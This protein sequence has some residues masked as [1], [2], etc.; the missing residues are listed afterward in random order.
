MEGWSYRPADFL[1]FSERVYWRLFE[2]QDAA[3]WP[4]Q[5]VA[6]AAG[7]AVLLLALRQRRGAAPA[8]FLIL[9]AAWLLVAVSFLWQR[10]L[11][12]NWAIAY[13]IPFFLAEAGLLLGLLLG[14]GGALAA[15]WSPRLLAAAGLLAYALLAHPLLP[16]V[17]A[18]P[19]ASAELFALAPDPTAIVTLAVGAMLVEPRSAWLIMPVP[20]LWCLASFATLLTLGSWQGWIVLAAPVLALSV[21]L[22]PADGP[23]GRVQA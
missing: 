13:A 9:A 17:A 20:A 7:G 8:I 12:V 22:L 18:R 6:L 2:L 3:L 4:L 15:P 10:Y 1:L 5:L 19:L 11:P 16:L 14:R 23:S 21:R